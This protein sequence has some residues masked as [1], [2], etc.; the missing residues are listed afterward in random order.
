MPAGKQPGA[1]VLLK[2]GDGGDPEAFT[3][4]GGLR[5]NSLTINRENIDVTD[6]DS[7]YWQELMAG[8]VRSVEVSA[9][10]LYKSDNAQQ[11]ALYDLSLADDNSANF[12]FFIPGGTGEAITMAGKFFVSNCG[13]P[14]SA[15][16]NGET[17]TSVTLQSSGAITL[18][19]A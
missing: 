10:M 17:S 4:L 11:Q 3:Q 18:T 13:L 8:G 6:K 7:N 15:E 2:I 19:R 1:L 5:S 9:G 12:E 16:Y 14:E